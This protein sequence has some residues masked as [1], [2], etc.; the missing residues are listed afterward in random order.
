MNRM[1][2]RP[3]KKLFSDSNY[4]YI[5]IAA[6]V[7]CL[8]MSFSSDTRSLYAYGFVIPCMLFLGAQQE[9]GKLSENRK[10]FLLPGIMVTW[11]LLLQLKRSTEHAELYNVGLFVSVYLFA[12]PLAFIL[13][14]G[15]ENKALKI[16]SGAYLVAAVILAA[17]GSLL[18]F[19]RLPQNLLGYVYWDGDRLSVLWHSNNIGCFLMIGIIFC[20]TFLMNSKS[21]W[22]R[23]S[24]SAI[25]VMMSGILALTSCRTAVIL[26]GCYFGSVIFYMLIRHGRKWFIPAVLAAFVVAAVFYSGERFLY[27]ANGDR[28]I[29]KYIQEYSE[30]VSE[31][32]L[33]LSTDEAE[34]PLE[35]AVEEE[36][37]MT[38]D[39]A[40][41]LD[42]AAAYENTEVEDAYSEED[43]LEE[44]YY[45]EVPEDEPQ[46][47]ALPITVD[48]ETGD[49]QL[50]TSSL[51]G[52][53]MQ[54]FGTFNS[55]TYIWAAAKLAI[56][57]NPS[58]LI[59]GVPDPGDYVSNYNFFRADHMHNAWMEC[60]MGMGLVGFLIALL[61][62]LMTA[63]NCLI[64]LLKHYQNIWKRNVAILALC[65]LAAAMLEPYLFYTTVDYNLVDVIFFMCAGYLA[66]WQEEDNRHI[67]EIIRNRFFVK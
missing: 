22:P 54:D 57:E 29:R 23:I 1:F 33:P 6:V 65:L 41:I 44:G 5:L 50:T 8:A 53:I 42:A 16:F 61:F 18:F 24:L 67:M 10:H 26:T 15:G 63:W 48:P 28:L 43:Y 34:L 31:N 3:I 37:T 30:Q 39:E 38:S 32:S 14:E 17:E 64:V 20:T 4:Y 27:K 13:K 25:L 19:D 52:D 21:I 9:R 62:T 58:I 7:A 49:I 35:E 36:N 2:F 45:E 47:E 46:E 12:F 40:D 60:L 66:Y 11:F 51:Q 59:W 56:R 55:R